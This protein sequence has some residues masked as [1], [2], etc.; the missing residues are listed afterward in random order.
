MSRFCHD[1]RCIL[2]KLEGIMR[3]ARKDFEICMYCRKLY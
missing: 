3:L 2:H 1:L